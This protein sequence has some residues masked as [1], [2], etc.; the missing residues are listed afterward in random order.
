MVNFVAIGD[1]MGKVATA[2][3]CAAAT[4]TDECSSRVFVT[5]IGV[6]SDGD[7]NTSHGINSG[8]GCP[9]HTVALS[10]FSSR[11]FITGDRGIGR[12]GDKYG[13][14]TIVNTGQSKVFSG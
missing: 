8:A 7:K 2:H 5:G 1:G 10:I 11:V 3:D 13:A 4:S 9:P 12:N 14:E 6:V